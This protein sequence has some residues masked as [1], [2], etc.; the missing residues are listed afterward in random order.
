MIH[1]G[2][3]RRPNKAVL[4]TSKSE[5]PTASSYAQSSIVEGSLPSGN[6][7]KVSHEVNDNGW[8]MHIPHK[9]H[10]QVAKNE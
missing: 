8:S 4:T 6:S 3:E 1:L 9:G 7:A 10:D 5:L 2:V